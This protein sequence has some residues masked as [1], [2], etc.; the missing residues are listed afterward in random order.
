MSK[1]QGM[2]AVER[3]RWWALAALALPIALY[4]LAY[5]V[6]ADRLYPDV[7]ADSFRARPWGIL[8][9]VLAG[10]IGLLI[11][12]LQLHPM[13]RQRRVR[14]H[15]ALGRVYAVAAIATGFA[16]MYMAIH[17]Y[18]GWITHVGFG[19]LGVGTVL[20]TTVAIAYIR[21][22]EVDAHRRWMIRSFALMYAAVTL[23]LE[24]PI[25]IGLAG[26]FEP[27]YL[28]VSWLCWVPNLLVAEWYVRRQPVARAVPAVA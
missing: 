1:V 14:L 11:G 24:L 25:L 3:W 26:A 21:R 20:T 27:A 13:L 5:L 9:H 23:R 22:R 18:G 7:L 16:G 10:G 4:A 19:L 8:P 2:T 17:S 28:T 6:T 15:R 12:P